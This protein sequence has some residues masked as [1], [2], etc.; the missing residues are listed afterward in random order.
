MRPTPPFFL[1]P[2]NGSRL[3][4]VQEPTPGTEGPRHT[5]GISVGSRIQASSFFGMEG[6]AGIYGEVGFGGRSEP[7]AELGGYQ[8]RGALVEARPTGF[9]FEVR[10]QAS[11][12]LSG[13][14]VTDKL[15]YSIGIGKKG[16]NTLGLGLAVGFGRRG[17]VGSLDLDFSIKPKLVQDLLGPRKGLGDLIP[18]PN[19]NKGWS[20]ATPRNKTPF[21]TWGGET[22]KSDSGGGGRGG[23]A[24]SR[25]RPLRESSGPRSA[26]EPRSGLEPE[27]MPRVKEPAPNNSGE[28]LGLSL[29]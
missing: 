18:W 23:G 12:N 15:N 2:S 26:T 19:F 10:Y 9:D 11:W 24:D 22:N 4:R 3:P 7:S 16:G 8:E 13:V 28:A 17:D 20:P 25:S 27:K 6:G 5:F 1:V 29:P 21:G 14:K